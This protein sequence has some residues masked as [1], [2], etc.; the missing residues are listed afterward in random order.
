MRDRLDF[1]AFAWHPLLMSPLQSMCQW[2]KTKRES[3][4]YNRAVVEIYSRHEVD[5]SPPDEA[6]VIRRL[7]DDKLVWWLARDP[8]GEAKIA[9]EREMRRRDAWAAPAGRAFKI[10]L[11]SLIVAVLALGLSAFNTA[12]RSGSVAPIKAGCSSSSLPCP[13]SAPSSPKPAHPRGQAN[14]RL[15]SPQR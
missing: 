3:R 11:I 9:L 13:S 14:H 2:F 1:T 15:H 12:A 5:L 8:K 6:F 4:I 10:S 7:S